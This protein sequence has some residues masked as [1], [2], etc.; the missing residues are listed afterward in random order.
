MSNKLAKGN[1]QTK[2]KKSITLTLLEYM[3]VIVS[4][5]ISVM[6][7]LY[8][9]DGYYGVGDCKFEIY[10]LLVIVGC[11]IWLILLVFYFV[12]NMGAFTDVIHAVKE[13]P[14]EYLPEI[15]LA[16]FLL[17]SVLSAAVG[18]NF[19]ECVMGYPGWY[20]GIF[21]LVSFG[22]LYYFNAFFGLY[23]KITLWVLTAVSAL[24]YLFGILHR[25]LIDPLG[26]YEGIA[27]N[28]KNQFLSTLGQ[29]TWYTSFVCTVLPLGVCV[30]WYAK[31]TYLQV[32]SGL[33]SFLGFCT[34]VTA[35]ADSA[36]MGFFGMMAVLLWFSLPDPWKMLRFSRVLVLSVLAPLFM[37][38]L[39][40]AKPNTIIEF[41]AI[42]NFLLFDTRMILLVTF[43]IL[44]WF[45]FYLYTNHLDKEGE[46]PELYTKIA[47]IVRIVVY[48]LA[49]LIV[50]FTAGI[51]MGSAKGTLPDS[52]RAVT[53]QVPYLT[54]GENWGNGRGR[55]WEL[56]WQMFKDMDIAHKL[57]GV[58]PDGFR[59]YAYAL[60]AERL[61]E[62]WGDRILTNAHNEILNSL[63][64]F[65]IIG[66]SQYIVFYGII[67][68]RFA[69][70]AKDT[71][72]TRLT[73]GNGIFVG[74][75]ACIV[76]YLCHNFFCYMTVCCTPFL[77]ILLGGGMSLCR[78]K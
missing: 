51:L 44:F 19:S 47:R 61:E 69:K 18:G 59:S 9:K 52:I 2:E 66:V 22:L 67:I 57:F 29:Q 50:L 15:I 65:G 60:Y 14:K 36:Y 48:A 34:I 71:A 6:V 7:P 31:K 40:M 41:D 53:E 38:F 37:K 17:F 30:F 5:A 26:T 58:G 4:C 3:T 46:I 73:E 63:I 45:A 25:L 11:G 70:A 54:W 68:A 24:T 42:S 20:M 32:L 75:I 16:S 13:N 72:K 10:K 28:Y 62:M 78:S 12:E 23:A 43:A 1:V 49:A 8:L 39:F 27:D 33:F 35:N 74:F 21:S 56:S 64:S 55:T 76:S 77:F